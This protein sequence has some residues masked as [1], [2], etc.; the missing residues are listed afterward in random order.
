MLLL[1]EGDDRWHIYQG[2]PDDGP[3]PYDEE[4]LEVNT[5]AKF[6]EFVAEHSCSVSITLRREQSRTYW[7]TV[8]TLGPGGNSYHR[9]GT[10]TRLED[11]MASAMIAPLR[12]QKTHA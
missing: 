5:V 10:G 6:E 3:V 2:E 7:Q 8:L 12:G 9:V 1:R 4:E 11:S